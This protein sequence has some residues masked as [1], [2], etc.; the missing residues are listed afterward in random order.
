M[1]HRILVPILLLSATPM[2]SPPP[3]DRVSPALIELRSQLFEAGEEGARRDMPRFRALCDEAGFP[4]VGNA[5]R[6]G[7]LYQPSQYCTA[8]RQATKGKSSA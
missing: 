3:D 1:P 6:K 4:L 5:V 7:K 2:S 8:V